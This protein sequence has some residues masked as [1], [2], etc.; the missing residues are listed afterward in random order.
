[1]Y[2]GW[3]R[4]ISE[5]TDSDD[6]LF[7]DQLAIFEMSGFETSVTVVQSFIPTGVVVVIRTPPLATEDDDRSPIQTA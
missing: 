4:Q 7:G 2:D 1:L 5:F 6:P 3:L